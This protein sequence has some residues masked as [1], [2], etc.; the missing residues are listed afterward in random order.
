MDLYNDDYPVIEYKILSY[1]YGCL[2][3]GKEPDSRKIDKS[4]MG[5]NERYWEKV[6]YSLADEREITGVYEGDNGRVVF[7]GLSITRKGIKR[8]FQD[9]M[10][11]MA[12][13]Y[14]KDTKAYL[15]HP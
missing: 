3:Q 15:P 7:K 8:L 1:L 14:L 9:D 11:R 10:M 2:K 5:I 4:K 12:S 6:I 13:E